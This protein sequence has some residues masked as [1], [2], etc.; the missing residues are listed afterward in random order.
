MFIN[1]F[2]NEV[3]LSLDLDEYKIETTYINKITQE[4]DNNN[5]IDGTVIFKRKNVNVFDL[6]PLYNKSKMKKFDGLIFILDDVGDPLFAIKFEGFF[7][8]ETSPRGQIINLE[9]L[10]S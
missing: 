4:V 7:K 9:N 8:K 2:V 10:K 1:F 5:I 6:G 3:P